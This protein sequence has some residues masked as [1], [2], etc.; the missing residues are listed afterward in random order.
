MYNFDF[1]REDKDY[2]ELRIPFENIEDI[3][4]CYEW[5]VDERPSEVVFYV[6]HYLDTKGMYNFY[7]STCFQFECQTGV[8][9]KG[10]YKARKENVKENSLSTYIADMLDKVIDNLS[11]RKD[12]DRYE[13][14]IKQREDA[15][16]ISMHM[17]ANDLYA[18]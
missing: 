9:S 14:L 3:S 1:I 8:C 16:I 11:W 5:M 12:I 10:I 7:I 13:E 15:G 6:Q 2:F 17:I 4:T 18:V